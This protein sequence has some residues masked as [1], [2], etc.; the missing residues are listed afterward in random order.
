M[1]W[2]KLD[3]FIVGAILFL[4]FSFTIRGFQVNYGWGGFEESKV[5]SKVAFMWVAVYT[6]ILIGYYIF[7]K[8]FTDLIDK[9]ADFFTE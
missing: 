5:L 9:I 7:R 4:Q 2:Y 1:K 8:V 3:Y 6:C